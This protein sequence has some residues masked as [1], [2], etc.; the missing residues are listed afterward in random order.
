[1]Y[2]LRY[3]SAGLMRSP[4]GP[5]AGSCRPKAIR[6]RSVVLQQV[7]EIAIQVLEHRYRAVG[8]LGW[9]AN[10]VDPGSPVPLIVTPEILRLEEEKHT[11]TSLVADHRE[12]IRSRG[13][14]E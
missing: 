13:S 10:E 4:F 8:L 2:D 12:L 9:R 5:G 7:P 14:G 6:D 11:A 3:P 1:S